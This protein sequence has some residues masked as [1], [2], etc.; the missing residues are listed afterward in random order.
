M[1]NA[2]VCSQRKRAVG[3]FFAIDSERGARIGL[4]EYRCAMAKARWSGISTAILSTLEDDGWR[5]WAGNC[6]LTS[7][8]RRRLDSDGCQNGPVTRTDFDDDWIP[9]A[10]DFDSDA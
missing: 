10:P 6:D 3:S 1:E 5:D 9:L 8:L 4:R 7:G 2:D